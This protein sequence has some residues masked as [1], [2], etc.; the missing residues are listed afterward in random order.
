[1]IYGEDPLR[2]RPGKSTGLVETTGEVCLKG[3][4]NDQ[5]AFQSRADLQNHAIG[6]LQRGY[7]SLGGGALVRFPRIWG[8]SGKCRIRTVVEILRFTGHGEKQDE[9]ERPPA[10]IVPFVIGGHNS[11]QCDARGGSR[12]P[13]HGRTFA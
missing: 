3:E 2:R 11:T 10:T 12:P 5:M 8:L 1:M 13:H 6:W 9:I 4:K 7:G